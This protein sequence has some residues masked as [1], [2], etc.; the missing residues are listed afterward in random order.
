MGKRGV[1]AYNSGSVDHENASAPAD[2]SAQADHTDH[3]S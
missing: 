2:A 1:F 3:D